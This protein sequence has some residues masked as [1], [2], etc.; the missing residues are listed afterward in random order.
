MLSTDRKSERRSP[1]RWRAV[2]FLSV[3]LAFGDPHLVVAAKVAVG[4]DLHVVLVEPEIGDGHERP[5]GAEEEVSKRSAASAPRNPAPTTARVRP[6]PRRSFEGRSAM[7]PRTPC[8][9]YPDA[10]DSPTATPP[11]SI[12]AGGRRAVDRMLSTR[13]TGGPDQLVTVQ[14]AFEANGSTDGSREALKFGP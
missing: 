14:P 3:R 5:P 6:G 13:F 9:P 10:P 12:W 11:P 1:V 2:N 8:S 4:A 7:P